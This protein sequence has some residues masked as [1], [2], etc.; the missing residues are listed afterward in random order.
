MDEYVIVEKSSLKSMADAVRTT[1]GSTE[2]IAVSALS[3]EVAN[4][5]AGGGLPSGG[6]PYQQ[7]VTDG[8]G[9]AKWQDRLA[10]ETDPVETEIIPQ[11]TVA[12]TDQ[13]GIMTALWP[14]NFDLVDGQTYTI[15]WDGVDYICTGILF[16]GVAPVL[17][18]LGL[19]G[20]GEDTGEPFIFMNQGQWM[21]GS[22]ESATEHVIGIKGHSAQ[23]VPLDEKYL[24]EAAFRV[25]NLDTTKSYS[26]EE[27]E[28]IY[29]SARSGSI[30]YYLN[31]SI[32]TSMYYTKNE[33]KCYISNGA[34]ISISPIDNVWDFSNSETKY[35]IALSFDSEYYSYAEILSR[36][37]NGVGGFGASGYEL[38][39]TNLAGFVGEYIQAEYAIVLKLRD[40][41]KYLY[42]SA[43]KNGEIEVLTRAV[44]QASGGVKTTLFKNGNDS[45]ILKSSTPGSSK[46]FKITVDDSGTISA[47]EVT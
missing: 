14:E 21:V 19:V 16:S 41:P 38:V 4:A 18:N 6:A 31:G 39:K 11:T 32:V 10:Y 47:T 27:I 30:V 3:N 15:S 46:K 37:Q 2:N 12:F 9:N 7:L 28:E 34:A 29:K 42:I 36:G 33:L 26:T 40:T 43:N 17:G 1:T 35:P 13:D 22:T 20:V 5:I 45:M 44:G 8:E 25:R 23:I 24:P